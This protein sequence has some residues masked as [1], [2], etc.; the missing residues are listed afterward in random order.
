M[1]QVTIICFQGKNRSKQ[2]SENGK[3]I[4]TFKT[5]YFL[6]MCHGGLSHRLPSC[7][8]RETNAGPLNLNAVVVG[9]HGRA[10][11]NARLTM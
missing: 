1:T 2:N 3:K 8:L 10:N 6:F 11:V 9:G 7:D 4:I 5:V